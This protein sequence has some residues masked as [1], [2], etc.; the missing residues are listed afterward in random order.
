MTLT[1]DFAPEEEAQLR[2]RAAEVGK[3]L[4][5]F[6]H[7]AMVY[8]ASRPSLTEILAPIHDATEKA[9]ISVDEIDRMADLALAEVRRER[10]A[11]IRREEP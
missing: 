11:A 10:R 8:E 6:V 7:D 2:Q 3:E 4:G 9:G 1:I 5:T